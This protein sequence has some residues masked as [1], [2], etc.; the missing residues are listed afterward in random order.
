[1]YKSIADRGDFVHRIKKEIIREGPVVAFLSS[2][3]SFTTYSS[4]IYQVSCKNIVALT[5]A[6]E[7]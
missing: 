1:L 7:K 4:G 3:Y 5:Y 6:L 2:S